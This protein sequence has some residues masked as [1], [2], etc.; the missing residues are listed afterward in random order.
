M[1]QDRMWRNFFSICKTHS[2]S[3]L[4]WSRKSHLWGQKPVVYRILR[5]TELPTFLLI[6]E[7]YSITAL[8]YFNGMLLNLNTCSWTF[9]FFFLVQVFLNLIQVTHTLQHKI[10]LSSSNNILAM[11]NKDKWLDLC[12]HT[13][14]PYRIPLSAKD[15]HWRT[16]HEKEINFDT[17]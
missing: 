2:Y 8:S 5:I 7:Y 12:P 13:Q 9:H 15:L 14:S 1:C 16:D 6:M 3:V 17:L 11:S 4:E 10:V